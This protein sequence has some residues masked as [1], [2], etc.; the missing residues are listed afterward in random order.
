MRKKD[1]NLEAVRPRG[2]AGLEVRV[3]RVTEDAAATSFP[4]SGIIS[5]L[6]FWRNY[7]WFIEKE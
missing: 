7:Y 3:C 2:T 5:L 4:K 6:Y 1:A